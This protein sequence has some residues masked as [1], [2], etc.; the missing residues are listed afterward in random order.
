[1][2]RAPTS[3]RGRRFDVSNCQVGGAGRGCALTL[4][5]TSAATTLWLTL[6]GRG[7]AVAVSPSYPHRFRS[8]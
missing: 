2:L 8:M 6:R 5:R 3:G 4:S 1:V 7:D